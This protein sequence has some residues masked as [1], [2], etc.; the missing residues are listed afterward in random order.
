MQSVTKLPDY[1][2]AELEALGAKQG[3]KNSVER[4]DLPVLDIV[5]DLPAD[6]IPADG[7]GGRTCLSPASETQCNRPKRFSARSSCPSCRAER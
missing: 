2:V 6:A 7:A 3:V 5:A 4:D 1:A